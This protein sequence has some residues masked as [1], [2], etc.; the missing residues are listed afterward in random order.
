MTTSRCCGLKHRYEMVFAMS[1]NQFL[2][3]YKADVE[4]KAK[5]VLREINDFADLMSYERDLFM[6]DVLKKMKDIVKNEQ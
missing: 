2:R 6:N 3:E 4:Q 1:D 5:N